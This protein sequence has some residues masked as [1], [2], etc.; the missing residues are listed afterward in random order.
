MRGHTRWS[1]FEDVFNSQLAA[2][3]PFNQLWSERP[4]QSK[5][6]AVLPVHVYAR[7]DSWPVEIVRLFSLVLIAL[8]LFPPASA[9]GATALSGMWRSAPE[10]LPLTTAFDESVWGKGAKSVR[11]VQMAVRPAGDATLTVTRK[12]VDARG[13][14]VPGSTSIEHADLVIGSVASSNQVRS[15]LAVTVKNA[16]RRYPDDPKATWA[17]EGL[18]VEVA[19]FND[20]PGEIEVRVDF[21]EGRGS[22]WEKLLRSKSQQ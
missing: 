5:R 3:R 1:P 2:D 12:V 21:P 16:E 22:F 4:A 8:T 18:R 10:E 6:S 20:T 11:T 7:E 14:T 15:E 9:A 17:L 13:R 19:T